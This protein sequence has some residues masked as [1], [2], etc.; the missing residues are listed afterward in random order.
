[1]AT[2]TAPGAAK[3]AFV[4]GGA[5]KSGTTT[6]DGLL[7]LHPQLQMAR[8]KETHYFDDETLDWTMPDTAPLDAFYDLSDP[9]M[10]GESTP[11]TLYWRPA[12][13]RL[14]RYNPDIKIILMLRDPVTRAFAQWKKSYAEGRE[15]LT[16]ADAIRAYP[17]RVRAFAEVEDLERHFS[18]VERGFYGAQ[19]AHLAA[20]V[21]RANIHVEIFEAFVDARDAALGRIAAFLGIAPFPNDL[22]PL[23]RHPAIAQDYPS[24]LGPEERAFL[25]ALYRDDTAALEAYLGRAIPAWRDPV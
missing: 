11:I 18:Y 4:I 5:Q 16:F 24:G 15:S 21:P 14:V 7:K 2:D 9:R 23:H 3:L 20:L 12:Q 8:K 6:L 22:P 17:E 10:R 1:M 13:H 19:L 25:R